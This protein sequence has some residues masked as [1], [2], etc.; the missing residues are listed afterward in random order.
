MREIYFI[1]ESIRKA[2]SLKRYSVRTRKDTCI[3]D[4]VE[5]FMT[6]QQPSVSKLVDKLLNNDFVLARYS[7]PEYPV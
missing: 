5:Y 7:D 4:D 3:H 2:S 1:T 6:H